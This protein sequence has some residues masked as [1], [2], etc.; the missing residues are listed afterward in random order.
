MKSRRLENI[1]YVIGDFVA[2]FAALYLFYR[3]E[4]NGSVNHADIFMRPKYIWALTL[5]PLIWVV[6]YLIFDSYRDVYRQSRLSV[7]FKT[8]VLGLMGILGLVFYS[9]LTNGISNSEHYIVAFIQ[10]FGLHFLF[11]V[12]LRMLILTWASRRLKSGK[13]GFKT[14]LIGNAA[15]ALAL[16]NDIKGQPKSLGHDFVGY[17]SVNG[18]SADQISSHLPYLGKD[19]NLSSIIQENEIEEA[20]VAIE[21]SEHDKLN[22]I[23]NK[24][25]DFKDKVLVRIVPDLYD[26]LLGTVKMNHVYGAV[27]IEIDQDLMPKWQRLVKRIIDVVVSLI[28]LI[29]LIPLFKYIIIRVKLSSEGPIFYKQERVGKNSVPFNILKFRSMYVNAED[30]GPQLSH[31]HDPRITS[32]GSVLRKWRLDELPQFWNVLQGD[33]SLVGPRP[34]RQYYIDQITAQAPHYKHLLKVRPGITSWGQVKYG[35]ASNLEQ[36]LQRLKF[37]I[38]YI[39]NMSLALDFKIIFYTLVVLI[40]GKGK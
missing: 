8:F 27:L 40:Q 16:Y 29:I 21:T 9:T 1:V 35:Y 37:D 34:E 13:V 15:N 31:D 38:L 7:F 22:N 28:A 3:M 33:M 32:W 24:L 39:E 26:I 19:E 11:T 4:V 2:A 6:Y 30:A 23:L 25:F 12:T 18:D 20:L 14:I 17:V 5:L 10:L 36:M